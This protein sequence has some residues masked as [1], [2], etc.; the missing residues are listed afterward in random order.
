MTE[1]Y[2]MQNGAACDVDLEDTELYEDVLA[3]DRARFHRL[4]NTGP[5][6][7]KDFSGDM[8]EAGMPEHFGNLNNSSKWIKNL[9]LVVIVGVVL[10]LLYTLCFCGSNNNDNEIDY[11]PNALYRAY[12]VRN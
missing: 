2:Y 6:C 8:Q 10:Y 11:D 4:A 12:F 7:M 3:K 9:L 1:R 5:R